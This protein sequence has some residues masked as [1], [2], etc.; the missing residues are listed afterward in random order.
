VDICVRVEESQE[1]R[2]LTRKI[3]IVVL[4][5]VNGLCVS[6]RNQDLDLFFEG[7]LVPDMVQLHENKVLCPEVLTKEVSVFRRAAVEQ[8]PKL[9]S[10]SSQRLL[11]RFEADF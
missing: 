7:C 6:L 1:T 5:K 2:K 4:C 8:Y 3:E 9:H 10:Q 11:E